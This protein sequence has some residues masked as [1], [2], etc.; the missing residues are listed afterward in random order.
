MAIQR[1]DLSA[2]MR[3]DMERVNTRVVEAAHV[4][5]PAV[6]TLLED[7]VAAGGKR[8][9]PLLVLLA[10]RAYEY[11]QHLEEL[12]TAAAGV[13]LLHTASLVH[14]DTVDRAAIRRG[15]P[16]LNSVL[17]NGA[18]ILIGDYL[19]A[20]SAMLA[21]ATGSPR[22]VSVFASTLG[23]LCDG[24]LLE[25]FDASKLD[26]TQEMYLRRISGKTAALFAGPAE[27]GAILGQAPEADIQSL[28][29]FGNDLG[30]AFQVV[31][32]IL[33]LTGGSEQI[34]KPAGHDLTQGTITLPVIYYLEGATP[35][36]H[37]WDQVEAIVSGRDTSEATLAQALDEIRESGSIERAM[38]VADAFADQTREAVERVPDAETRDLLH[39]FAD[40]MIHRKR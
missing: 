16:T 27:M 14:D 5:Y 24:Q 4:E 39:E 3:D 32:D 11:D 1:T 26:Q 30:M 29:G 10:G 13:E 25:M 21:A 8:L 18:V 40:L 2:V 23:D 15:K 34:G 17:N 38:L 9:R 20:Q 36:T 28:R 37:R 19:F 6:S 33:D 12:V 35:G 7:I 31:D 22:V